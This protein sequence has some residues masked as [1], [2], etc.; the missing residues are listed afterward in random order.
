MVGHTEGLVSVLVINF[1]SADETVANVHDLLEVDWPVERLEVIVVDNG[2]GGSDLES[3]RSSFAGSTVVRVVE[4]PVNLGFTGGVNLAARAA[5]GEFLAL[6]NSD[7]RPERAWISA[8]VAQFD[9]RREVAAVASKVLDWSGERIDFVAGSVTWFGMGYKPH[10]GQLAGEQ[11]DVESDI[12]F[13]TGA[14]LFVRASVFAEVGGLDEKLFMFYD[15]VDLGWR[16]NLLGHRVRYAPRSVVR[17][18]HHGSMASFGSHRELFLLERN[19]LVLLYKYLDDASLARMLPAALALTARRAAVRGGLSAEDFDLRSPRDPDEF[20]ADAPYSKEAVAGLVAIDAFVDLLPELRPERE[21]L[22]HERRVGD[23]ELFTKFGEMFE[24]LLASP[25][26]VAGYEA[27]VEAFGIADAT[28]RTRVLVLTGDALGTRMAGPGIRAWKMSEELARH[29]DVRLVTWNV[30]ER[31]SATFGVHRVR[32]QNEREMRVH[33]QWADVIVLQGSAMRHFR[34]IEATTKIVVADLYDPVH[35]EALEQGRENGL[36]QWTLQ[37]A[38]ATE[39]MNQQLL[40][41]DFFLCANERQRLFWLGH[42]AALGRLNPRVYADDDTLDSLIGIVPFGRDAADP[43]HTR[44]AIRGVVEGIGADD[45]LVIW[46]GGIYSWFDTHTLVT[47]IA[48]LA[49][50]RPD[51]RLYFMGTAHPNPDVP[52][53]AIVGSTRAL[54]QRLGVLDRNVFFNDSWVALDD[55]Q[56]YLLEADAGVSTHYDHLETTFSFRTR[57]LD[58]LWAGLPIVSTRGD[59]FGDLVAA[60][61]LGVAV[62]ARDVTALA[63]ALESVLYDPQAAATARAGVQR[64]RNE[65][66][67][68]RALRPLIDFCRDPLP[69]ADRPQAGTP[70]TRATPLRRPALRR[71]SSEERLYAIATS[72]HGVVRDASLALHYLAEGGPAEIAAKVRSRLDNRR[73]SRSE[74]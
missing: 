38:G 57:I 41:A 70:V 63:E 14:A 73:R 50:R 10:L 23:A 8:A 13:G 18:R 68:E 21:R 74:D 36:A 45:K 53:M 1:R 27:L 43:V 16:L 26:Y 5:R 55:R 69:A 17:H 46:G 51:V 33:E 52:E 22:Q 19:A 66:V 12:L 42:L 49:R 59:S 4:S 29:C 39:M 65:F 11:H 67:W 44:P 2:S 6:L 30:A 25:R 62:P 20:A 40:R 15:D 64:V 9:G 71:R 35:L 72:R 58:Y 32:L 24:P 3:L 37:V 48:E 7:A 31:A 47:A 61:G 34:T 28:R 54:A 60:E 56:N